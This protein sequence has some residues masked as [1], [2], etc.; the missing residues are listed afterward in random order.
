VITRTAPWSSISSG[1]SDMETPG[2]KAPPVEL[3]GAAAV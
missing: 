2:A 1:D 3:V